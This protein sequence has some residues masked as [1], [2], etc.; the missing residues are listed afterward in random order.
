[1]N[2]D[3]PATVYYI[4]ATRFL[5]IQL[6]F[7]SKLMEEKYGLTCLEKTECGHYKY[8]DIHQDIFNEIYD[9]VESILEKNNVYK[10]DS[11]GDK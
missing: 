10:K 11:Q 1:M 7:A 3:K 6:D 4:P 2:K 8:T 5:G 9:D